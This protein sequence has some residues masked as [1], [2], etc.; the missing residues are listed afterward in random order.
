MKKHFFIFLT[1]L[2]CFLI[3]P[4][5]VYSQESKGA[6]LLVDTAIRYKSAAQVKNALQKYQ[7]TKE[8]PAVEDYVKSSIRKL[9]IAED[10]DFAAD[11]IF[12][13][14]ESNIDADYEDDEML[15]LYGE[16]ILIYNLR[17]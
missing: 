5:I 12:A 6:S 8:Y 17:Q 15:D 1:V 10:Y 11:L 14:I 3:N 13:V 7:N 16:I 2:S 9:I 4:L